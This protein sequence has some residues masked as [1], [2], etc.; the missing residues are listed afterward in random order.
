MC[1]VFPN[2]INW[3]DYASGQYHGLSAMVKNISKK[4]LVEQLHIAFV[5]MPKHVHI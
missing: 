3:L 5:H 2:Q 4:R 1:E